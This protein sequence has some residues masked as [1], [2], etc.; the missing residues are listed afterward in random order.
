MV[1]ETSRHEGHPVH[2]GRYPRFDKRGWLSHVPKQLDAA[3]SH[4]AVIS[5]Y[6][7]IPS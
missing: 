6:A 1:S 2:G 4:G 3:A 5:V 7:G